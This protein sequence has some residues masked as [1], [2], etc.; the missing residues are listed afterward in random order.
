M[1]TFLKTAD[2]LS[3]FGAVIAGV[4]LTA[5]VLLGGAEVVLRSFFAISLPFVI[6]YN[7]YLLALAFLGGCGQAMREGGHIRVTMLLQALPAR[8]ARIV[9]VACTLAGLGLAIYLCVAMARLAY[10]S[11]AYGTLSFYA[12]RT[13]LAYPQAAVALMLAIFALSIL[14]RLMRLI[15]GEAPERAATISGVA[16]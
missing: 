15:I 2:A 5:L 12:T 11:Y 7:G 13:P 10:G 1:R 14:A 6:E 16:H 4:A 9:D 3:L 8:V